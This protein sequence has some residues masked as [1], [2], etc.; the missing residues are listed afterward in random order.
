M[1]EARAAQ[2]SSISATTVELVTTDPGMTRDSTCRRHASANRQAS[3]ATC[4]RASARN[5]GRSEG[6]GVRGSACILCQMG[7]HME[8]PQSADRFARIPLMQ[9]DQKYKDTMIAAVWTSPAR[10][11]S[12]GDSAGANQRH[13]DSAAVSGK[14]EKDRVNRAP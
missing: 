14:K 6:W 4:I 13:I 10:A 2:K 11:P 1:R 3:P 9:R 5:V 8:T 7:L 12:L